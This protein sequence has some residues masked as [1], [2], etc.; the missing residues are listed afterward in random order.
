MPSDSIKPLIFI[1]YAHLDEPDNP[2]AGDVRW[3]TFE[4]LAKRMTNSV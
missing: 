4:P 3:L 1:S 2:V